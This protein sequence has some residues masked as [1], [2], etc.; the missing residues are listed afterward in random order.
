[1]ANRY[2]VTPLRLND[3]EKD[4][5]TYFYYEIKH[6]Q[7]STSF[8]DN[9]DI[10]AKSAINFAGTIIANFPIREISEKGYINKKEFISKYNPQR[11][12]RLE[13]IK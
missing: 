8:N 1:M 5:L 11:V 12:A 4:V 3:S 13:D 7:N 6:G 9:C 2:L 10:Q